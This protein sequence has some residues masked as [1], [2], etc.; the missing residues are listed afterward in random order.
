MQLPLWSFCRQS[1]PTAWRFDTLF[2]QYNFFTYRQVAVWRDS[3]SMEPCDQTCAAVPV[4]C[5]G[6]TARVS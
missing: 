1:G 2:S 3:L 4:Q 6:G 5:L